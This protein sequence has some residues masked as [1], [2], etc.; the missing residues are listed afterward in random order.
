VVFQKMSR[1]L[2]SNDKSEEKGEE[3]RKQRGNSEEEPIAGA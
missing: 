3:R 2:M 1:K